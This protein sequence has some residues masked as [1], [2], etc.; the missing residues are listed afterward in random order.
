M[1][2]TP[3]KQSRR[4]RS[5]FIL[6]GSRSSRLFW[7]GKTESYNSKK[8]GSSIFLQPDEL[9]QMLETQELYQLDPVQKLQVLKGLCL[10][11]M[12]TYSVQDFMEEKQQESSRLW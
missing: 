1:G 10:R 4:P 9:I 8:C 12:S 2:F 6:D 11:I 7:R 5:I 3:L